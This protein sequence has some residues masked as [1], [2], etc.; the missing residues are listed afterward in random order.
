VQASSEKLGPALRVSAF[1]TTRVNPIEVEDCAAIALEMADGS[2]A[3][4]T[5]TLGSIAQI[6]RHRFCFEHMA[7]ES[8]TAPYANSSEPWSFTADFPETDE[9]IRSALAE[10]HP[11]PEGFEGQFLRFSHSLREGKPF[12]V[13]LSDARASLE[14]ATA[15]YHAADTG[16]AVTLPLSSQHPF[17]S[18]W[19]PSKGQSSRV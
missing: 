4:L 10:F 7:A 15:I 6:S 5:V 13:T 3:S 19:Q 2:V 1:I 12:P 14:L 11:L 9:R 16:C 8:G 17:Y 18:G